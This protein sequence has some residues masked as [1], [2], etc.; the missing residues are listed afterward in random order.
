LPTLAKIQIPR[1][2]GRH[3][4]NLGVEI[5]GFADAS[6][7]AYSAIVYLRVFH[8][9][10]D[11]RISLLAAKTK[12]A[13]FKTVSVP[14][15]KLNVVVLLSRLIGWVTDAL[16]LSDVP[17]YGW[18]DS[19]VTLAWLSQHPARWKTYVANRVSEV[20]TSQPSI[21]WRHVPTHE[22]PADC[23]FRGISASELINHPLWWSGPQ[24]LGK[25]SAAWP[26]QSPSLT[27]ISTVNAEATR[28]SVH[29][30]SCEPEFNLIN[31]FS[32]WTKLIRVTA[33][34]FRFVANL[35]ARISSRLPV[36]SRLSVSEI[37]QAEHHW[38]RYIQTSMFTSERKALER[39]LSVP[40]S[41]SAVPYTGGGRTNSPWRAA[42][43][44][45][46]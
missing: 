16:G 26:D 38:L 40:Q 14:R 11:V 10:A 39:G 37:D 42:R 1:W 31:K 22:N 3:R 2:T 32:S 13:P 43:S 44:C 45:S 36:L 15:L 5:H 29:T 41:A 20:Q 30:T 21:K 6:T 4:D 18:T 34:I 25:H 7:R 33:Y 23:A 28:A 27:A 8:S 35:R 46:T 19:S 17:L 9:F 24:W 12:V